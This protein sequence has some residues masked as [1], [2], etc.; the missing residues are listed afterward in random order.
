M[1]MAGVFTN[2]L[3][4]QAKQLLDSIDLDTQLIQGVVENHMKAFFTQ[5]I[6]PSA[7]VQLNY[8][9][10]AFIEKPEMQEIYKQMVLL[11][12]RSLI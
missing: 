2:Q 3:W 6:I 8:E 5:Q 10:L 7:S 11:S 1:Q 12:Q 4:T 9:T